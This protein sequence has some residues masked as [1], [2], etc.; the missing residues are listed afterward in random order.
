[1][2]EVLSLIAIGVLSSL[3][4]IVAVISTI[5]IVNVI[6]KLLTKKSGASTVLFEDHQKLVS[7]TAEPYQESYIPV[8]EVES[9]Y[10]GRVDR[11]HLV[12]AQE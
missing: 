4:T 11:F 1:M 10:S 8:I 6:H 9:K 7:L 2:Y 5:L 3:L 12:R